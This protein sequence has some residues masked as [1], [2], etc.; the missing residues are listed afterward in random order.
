MSKT[1]STYM[2]KEKARV[3]R[4]NIKKYPWAREEVREKYIS[5]AERYVD[6]IDLLYDMVI[7]EGIPRSTCVGAEGDPDMY[8]CRYCG[9]DL[10]AKYADAAW[11]NNPFE[12]P[13]KIKC[14]DCGRLFP[15]NDFGSFYKLGLDEYGRFDRELAHK[16]NDELIAKGEAG[17]LVNELYPEAEEKFGDKNWGVDDGFGYVTGKV[18]DNGVRERHTYIA[19]YLHY[20]MW[21]TESMSSKKERGII[22]DAL[23]S[24]AYSFFYTGDLK[25][26]RVA[27]ILLDRIADFYPD[28]DISLYGDD[29]WNSDGGSNTGKTVGCI[30]ETFNSRDFALCYDMV[31]D[32]YEDEFVVNFLRDKAKIWKM[33]NPKNN[34]SEIRENVENRLIREILKCIKDCTIAGNFGFPQTANAMAAVVLDDEKETEEWL[35]YLLSPGWSRTPPNLGGGINE[36]LINRIDAD[37]QGDEASKYNAAWHKTLIDIAEILEGQPLADLYRNPKFLQMFFSNIPLISEGY[38]PQIGD[39]S[40][41]QGNEHWMS[42]KVAQKGFRTF[43]DIRFAQIL[44]ML[45]GNSAKGLHD[46]ITREKPESLALDVQNIIDKYG[47]FKPQ[48]D[49]MTSFGFGALRNE[50]NDVWMYF[51]SN[52][53][54]GH[55]DTLNLGM[56]AYGLNFLPDLGYPEKTGYQPNRLQWVRSTLSHNTVMVD[57]REQGINEEIRGKIKHFDVGKRVSV[58]DVDA[59]YVYPQCEEY[60]RSIVNISIEGEESYIVDFFRVK[61]GKSALLSI[62]AS[63]DEIWETKGINLDLQVDEKGDFIGSFAGRDVPYGPDPNSPADWWYETV[64]PRGYT[65]TENVGRDENLSHKAEVDFAIKDFNNA[66]DAPRNLHLR[67]TFLN[68][69]NNGTKKLS[70]VDGYPPKKGIN[71]NIHCLKYV[72][73]EIFD[74]CLDTVFT[75]VLEPYEKKRNI[76][77]IKELNIS[78]KASRA[79]KVFFENGREDYIIYS[80][81]DETHSLC[82]GDIC[83]EFS[84]FLGVYSYKDGKRVYEYV[85]GGEKIDG[86]VIGF[87]KDLSEENEIVIKTSCKSDDICGSLVIVDNGEESRGSA[88]KIISSEKIGEKVVLDIGRVTLIRGYE[89]IMKPE[90]GYVYSIRE[91]QKIR[92]PITKEVQM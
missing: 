56:T 43:G 15:S 79:L 52:G 6:K 54:H 11:L 9:C 12:Y 69:K 29:V 4:E 66:F 59:S 81:Y 49:I 31:F 63:S 33:P 16:K 35:S 8:F 47:E 20:G 10:G 39:T 5:R 1:K 64:Y 60:R 17:Y 34:A 36:V 26:G 53:G 24:S 73:E 85:H 40:F 74:E 25:Y 41:T 27:A 62:H 83:I 30:W 87:T 57:G 22:M 44:Y 68:K 75:T 7:G 32:A 18:Y 76:R 38:S 58:L 90:K 3:A 23:L 45:N 82:D 14:P 42:L 71:K 80:P 65:W 2:T 67:A 77:E 37:G 19:Q 91:G 88:Y 84:G 13:W 70:I 86:E 50:K 72:F 55:R 46:E 51:G 48:S 61:G 78:G 21:Y 28:Y 92:I 89:D